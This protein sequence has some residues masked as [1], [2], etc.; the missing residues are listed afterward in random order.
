MKITKYRTKKSLGQCFILD[1]AIAEKIVS[2]AGCLEQYN[3]IEV[4]PG[5]GIMTQSILNK[6][7]RRLTAIEKD[8]RLSNI[9]SKLKEAHTEYDCI[10]EDILDVNIEQLLS[11]SPLKMISNLPYN[12]SVILL[13]KLLPYIHR[14]EKLILMFQKEVADRIVAQPNTKSYSI[15]SILVQLLC[16]VRKVEDF[17]PEIFSPSPKVYSS[18]IEITPLLSPRFSADNSYFA[19]VLK[20]LFHCRRKTIR[21]SLKSCI[22]DADALFIGCNIDPNARA[23]SLTIEQLCSLTNALKARNINII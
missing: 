3:V 5:L 11:Q 13:L 4:G 14:F 1:P 23:E 18:V 21:N 8:R 22:K 9:H 19:Q 17:P 20:K 16:D 12:I 10:F 6:G 15:L 2:Y 7:V